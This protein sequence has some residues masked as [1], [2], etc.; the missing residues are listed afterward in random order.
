MM[1]TAHWYLLATA[2]RF[3]QKV[4]D[5]IKLWWNLPTWCPVILE[6]RQWI[7]QRQ[8]IEIPLLRGHILVYGTEAQRVQAMRH[9][10]VSHCLMAGDEPVRIADEEIQQLKAFID[11]YKYVHGQSLQPGHAVQLYQGAFSG[12]Q[13]LREWQRRETVDLTLHQLGIRLE[14]ARPIY[15]ANT[16]KQTASTDYMKTKT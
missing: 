15:P 14:A 10:G 2:P 7:S 9:H 8:T 12:Q 5:Q 6:S 16:N 3:E 1:T 4:A 11:E 13:G